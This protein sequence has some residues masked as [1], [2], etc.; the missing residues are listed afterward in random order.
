[1]AA[2]LLVALPAMAQ[3]GNNTG[4]P[5]DPQP[6]G[7][8]ERR[9]H[10]HFLVGPTLHA[11][12]GRTIDA[13]LIEIRAGRIVSV[14]EMGEGPFDPPP[15]ARAHDLAGRHV[16][17]GFIDAH[18]PVDA[19]R[20]GV[21]SPGAH[22]NG[23]VMPQRSALDGDGAPARDAE[24]LRKLGFAA[25]AI[26]PDNGIF[27]G[28]AAVVSLAETPADPANGRPPVYRDDAYHALSLQRS[29]SNRG[30]FNSYPNS[31]MGAIALIRQTLIDAD[32]ASGTGFQPVDSSLSYL[33]SDLPLL[34]RTRDELEGLRAIKIAHEFGR[35]P[36]VLGTGTEFRRLD[37]IAGA[38][39]G[40]T[41]LK[42]RYVIP[43]TLPET[44]EIDTVGKADSTDL[45]DLMTWEQAPTN[46]RRLDEA[47]VFVAITADGLRRG[48]KFHDNLRKAI[49]TGGLAPERALAMLTT[50]PASILGLSEIAGVVEPGR[51]ANLVVAS[52]DLF[53][54]EAKGVQILDVWIDG[55]AH[56]INAPEPPFDGEWDLSVGDTVGLRLSID[57]KRITTSAGEGED[58]REG[59]ARAVKTTANTISFLLDDP[60]AGTSVVSGVLGR[61]GVIRGSGLDA[62]SNPFTWSATK[63]VDPSSA[64]EDGTQEDGLQEGE[65]QEGGLSSPPPDP[66]TEQGEASDD[67]DL[68][69]A[70]LPGYPFGPYAVAELPPQ[71]TVLFTNGTIWTSGP[72]GTIENGWVLIREGRIVGLG[73][74]AG[75]APGQGARVVDLAGRHLTP[76]LLD[77]HS[78]TGISRGVNE[79]GQSVT[80][81]VRI[82]DVTDPD[83]IN[84]YRQLAGGVTTVNSMHGSANPIGGQTQT[85]KV[86]WGAVHPDDMHMQGAKPGIKFALG[87]NVKQSNWNSSG[88]R[89]PQTRMGV[90]TIIRD[91]F[92]AA[93]EY[94][95]AS[96][97]RRDLELEALAEI[98]AGERLVHCHSYRQDE[99][100]ML[101]RVAE[102]FGF[103]IGT[104][105][106][107]LEVYKVA[108]AVR[109]H[110]I[111]ASLFSDWWAYK[112]EVQDAIAQ[113]GPLQHEVGVNTSYNS[114][115]D[116]LARRMH[117]E[118]AKAYKYSDGRL[119]KE[120]ALRFVTINPAIQLGIA[121]RVGSIEPG[122]DADL[123][124]WSGEPLSSLSMC[125]A[126]WI[127]GREYFSLERDA[128]LRE[129]NAAHRKRITQKILSK[130]APKP[131]T[132]RDDP[133]AE[134]TTDEDPTRSMR[135]RIADAARAEHH[136]NLYLRG[137]NPADHRCGDCGQTELLYGTHR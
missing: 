93:R 55:R 98:L 114:D 95:A 112:V 26:A 8:R 6:N 19:P 129:Q 51:L 108:E 122:K 18:L 117:V 65:I 34:F 52:G 70:D 106:H 116:E 53:D 87:E 21:D 1:M 61:D 99:I 130:G 22:W 107:G 24:R 88:T 73:S 132:D 102:D 78:H 25:A 92:T 113:A 127:D 133:E 28:R 40:P 80:A 81:E 9:P 60:D 10:W 86:R 68:P 125:E 32:W 48:E 59:K 43:L 96:G 118:A 4:D 115:S 30:E 42:A 71:E 74:G 7:P 27:A 121:D 44:P 103:K 90:E 5:L 31:Q 66:D 50:N 46:A 56:T 109:E 2:S 104:F 82:G 36:L 76:G 124:I 3:T 58:K 16:Y 72:E 63:T 62:E 135:Q 20:P 49:K 110:A 15:G 85:N 123:A 23:S 47:G 54:A 64:R 29:G 69:P 136:F 41:E 126:T 11:A 39:G 83:R 131:K 91:R 120:E 105:Q 84:W 35:A 77:A 67:S 13:A 57:G 12:P 17:A 134:E 38:S 45:R 119:T 101:C 37:A 137:I 89:Y 33:S 79:S 14:A 97:K 100:L 75:P 128:A 111:G 94:A